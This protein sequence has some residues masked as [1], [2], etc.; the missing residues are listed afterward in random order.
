MSLTRHLII[1]VTFLYRHSSQVWL[2]EHSPI[3]SCL[4][5]LLAFI[6]KRIGLGPVIVIRRV[7]GHVSHVFL[8]IILLSVS[9]LT[10]HV[11]GHHPVVPSI[12]SRL[13]V[14]DL[15]ALGE[16]LV[17]KLRAVVLFMLPHYMQRSSDWC[18]TVNCCEIICFFH[19]NCVAKDL[20]RVFLITEFLQSFTRDLLLYK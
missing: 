1:H 18:L 2:V 8:T 17:R 3:T 20:C 13:V 6:C 9:Y 15:V 10:G 16:Y 7:Q 12:L 5:L 14:G 11:V 19:I 4:I